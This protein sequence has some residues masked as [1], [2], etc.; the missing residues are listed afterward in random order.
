ESQ[1]KTILTPLIELTMPQPKE[2]G[3]KSPAEL[4]QESINTLLEDAPKIAPQL[5]KYWG[6]E[7]FF[8]DVQLV[9]GSVRAKILS[10]I[11]NDGKKLDVLMAPMVTII[12][13]VGFASDAQT[14]QIAVDIAKETGNGLCLRITESNFNKTLA[15]DI[16][17]FIG[18]H[19]LDVKNVDLVVDFKIVDEQ[20]SPDLL[21]RR[22]NLIPHIEEWRTFTVA[23]G[24]FPPDLSQF[25]K[26]NQYEISRLDWALWC[27]LKSLKRRPSFA[28]YAIQHPIYLP[29]SS[30]SNPSASIRYTLEDHWVVIRGEG[31]RNPKG[32][33]FKQYPALAQILV[34]QKDIFKGESF[35]FGDSYIAEKGKDINTKNT[36]NPK[37]WLE[38]GINHHL[39]LA[40][41]Q[42]ASAL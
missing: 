27:K 15:S 39:T 31:L 10:R 41:R 7:K 22:I 6:R 20:T 17:A 26:H 28:D 35:S 30:A 23:S 25:E 8:L 29:R 34:N 12:P 21:C 19:G 13:V 5:L 1:D 38:A 37:T 40:A 18:K 42:V 3:K 14:R 16:E 32:A 4:L 33:G 11:L 24:A 36:G 2:E 9:D